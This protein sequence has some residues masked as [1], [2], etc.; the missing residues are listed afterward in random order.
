MS[1]ANSGSDVPNYSSFG[2]RCC[3]LCRTSPWSCRSRGGPTFRA[4]RNLKLGYVSIC[5]S[6]AG[7]RKSMPVKERS[8]Q[9]G[10]HWPEL[11]F[12][13]RQA[14]QCL[15]HTYHSLAQTHL[16]SSKSISARSHHRQC[17]VCL[18]LHPSR[19]TRWDQHSGDQHQPLARS[20]PLPIF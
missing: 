3:G 9:V 10:K 15:Q 2:S 5:Y 7:W 4:R 6:D 18:Y 16:P 11:L 17:Y 13:Q 12:H 19:G 8:R 20:R 14:P 1:G